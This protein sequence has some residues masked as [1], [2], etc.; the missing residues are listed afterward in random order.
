[1][2]W[3]KSQIGS[4]DGENG[5]GVVAQTTSSAIMA[6]SRQVDSGAGRTA[7]TICPGRSR[8]I[9]WMA[10]GHAAAGRESIVDQDHR[11]ALQLW[12]RV[13]VAERILTTQQ[14]APLLL[15]YSLQRLR[16]YVQAP[17]DRR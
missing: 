11:L 6:R 8:P 3:L 2:V 16:R 4:A 1:V 12:R 15:R 7:T 10:A 13:A 17:D 14:L 5:V 9:A